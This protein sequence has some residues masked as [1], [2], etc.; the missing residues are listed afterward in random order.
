MPEDIWDIRRKAPAHFWAKA[1]NARFAA[2]VLSHQTALAQKAASAES[3]YMAST[4]I[5]LTEGFLRES[6]IA[7]ELILKAAILALSD[8]VPPPFTHDVP[9]LWREAKL[10][11]PSR[12]DSYRLQEMAML[13]DWSGRY[14]A[15][16]SNEKLERQLA[17]LKRF[18]RTERLGTLRIRKNIVLTWEDFDRLYQVAAA[19]YFERLDSR[20]P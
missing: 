16:R 20:T 12:D 1:D 3:G 8:E 7:M 4:G 9:R 6:S 19:A 2:Y 11:K 14:G 15:P 18:E 17:D 10:P 13:L 5:A